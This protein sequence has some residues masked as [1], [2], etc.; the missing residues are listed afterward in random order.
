M[1]AFSTVTFNANP[2]DVSVLHLNM[3]EKRR[4]HSKRGKFT[5]KKRKVEDDILVK[6]SAFETQ[7]DSDFIL[8][9]EGRRIVE[10]E[11]LAEQLSCCKN[12]KVNTQPVRLS[13]RSTIRFQE[14]IEDKMSAV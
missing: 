7:T 5:W 9:N 2:L 3:A 11:Y 10:L 1:C 6:S 14:R 12:V 8:W 4:M 13:C